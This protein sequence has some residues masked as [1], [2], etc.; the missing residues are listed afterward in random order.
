VTTPTGVIKRSTDNP[1]TGLS[2][3]YDESTMLQRMVSALNILTQGRRSDVAYIGAKNRHT[4]VTAEEVTRK[5]QCGIE[6]AKLTLKSTTQHGVRQ[7]IHPLR[8]MYR[9]DHIDINCRR[10][11]DTFYMDTLFSKEKSINGNVCA[12]VI[13]N[14]HFMRVLSDAVKGK[15]EY[16]AR[17]IARVY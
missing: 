16:C 10:L 11:Q 15:R 2:T 8:R 13:T 7:A 14:G 12:Q 6:T 1:L 4:Q 9:V 5:F 17:S 3:V